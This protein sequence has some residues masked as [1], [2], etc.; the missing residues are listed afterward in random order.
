MAAIFRIGLL[1]YHFQEILEKKSK[2][3]KNKAANKR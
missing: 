3:S 1:L 2:E